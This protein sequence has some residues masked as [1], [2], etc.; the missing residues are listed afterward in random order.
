LETTLPTQ[1][2]NF[3]AKHPLSPLLILVPSD[4]IRRRLKV[5]L[6]IENHL[7][8]I[9]LHVLTFHQLSLKLL[10]ERHLA[11]D[12]TL[13]EDLFFEEA[14]R[15][16]VMTDQH[17]GSFFFALEETEGGI[18]ALWQTLRDMKDGLVDPNVT[19]QALEEGQFK[20][21]H[22]GKETEQRLLSLFQIYR[23]FQNRCQ[24]RGIWGYG[25]VSK[26][27]IEQVL[28]SSFLRQFDQ[29]F[30]Y[31]F[32]DLTQVQIDLFH[33]VARHYQTMLF[34]PF[35]KDHS[36]WSFSERFFE[37][38]VE[39]LVSDATQIRDLSRD[40]AP[41]PSSP[42]S[43][44]FGEK[45][46][47]N[48]I[49][50]P[51]CDAASSSII[52]CFDLRDEVLYVSKEIVRLVR[53][54]G[55]AFDDISV[56]S[57]D[58]TPYLSTI[59]DLFQK[60]AIP[61]ASSA[62]EP[63][64]QFPLAKT[65]SLMTALPIKEYPR[66]L[67]IDL[68]SSP[69]FLTKKILPQNALPAPDQWDFLSRKAG[70]IKGLSTW[71]RLQDIR[72][73]T[74]SD[75]YQSQQK[76][77]LWTIFQSVHEDINRLPSVASWS[78]FSTKWQCLFQKYLKPFFDEQKDPVLLSITKT[79]E[80]LSGLDQLKATVN[81]D[82]FIQTFQRWLA[83]QSVPISKGNIAG[84]R[85][86][87]LMSARGLPS[88]HR[89]LLGLNEGLFP[90]TIRED[91]F[92]PDTC[93]YVMETV[94]GYKIGEKHAGYEEER[95]LLRLTADAVRERLYV[96][97]HRVDGRGNSLAPSWYLNE[98]RKAFQTET[99]G[100]DEQSVPQGLLKKQS[101]LPF[102]E[103]D[104][105]LATESALHLSLKSQDLT[106]LVE[107]LPFSRMLYQQTRKALMRLEAQGPLMALDGLIQPEGSTW[108]ALKKKRISPT[109]LECYARCPFQ[110]FSMKILKLRASDRP[111][112]ATGLKSADIGQLCHAILKAFYSYFHQK[113]YLPM[114]TEQAKILRVLKAVSR[115]ILDRYESEEM[116]IY[117]LFW[118]ML[119]EKILTMLHQML[120][121]DLKELAVSGFRP[122]AFEVSCRGQVETTWPE[123]EGRLD[124]IDYHSEA[125]SIRVIDYKVTLRKEPKTFEKNLLLSAVRGLR[126][127]PPL[128]QQL[129]GVFSEEE[130][131]NNTE[132]KTI[133]HY[134][135]PNWTDGPLVTKSFPENAWE[136]ETGAMLKETISTLLHGM[137]EGQFYMMP[138]DACSF[139]EISEICRKNHLPSRHRLNKD[140]LWEQH[141]LLQKKKVPKG[142]SS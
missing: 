81:R 27:A 52:S 98:L 119:K 75:C 97:Y 130:V 80:S 68:V 22:L 93:R 111:E 21:E 87:G 114:L 138:G 20:K 24:A 63:I 92:L 59:K 16:Q 135:A 120:L 134:I 103:A 69:L 122:V 121:L 90:R 42:A 60:Y 12:L 30:Y 39:G 116:V 15:I 45:V 10:E 36:E 106:P 96:L 48:S 1:V 117:P 54:G 66:S 126:L 76:T 108:K 113:N 74:D 18:A 82:H 142:K 7:N 99:G 118:E 38:Y 86:E 35:V 6:T 70:V 9:H 133:F 26:M 105:F 73:V 43:H 125:Q 112:T 71:Q 47:S 31:G 128:Y 64:I 34:F 5:L 67:F 37:R 129:S 32:Y 50:H 25:D 141:Q 40:S 139:C 78:E 91:P 29:I 140:P 3:K 136:G 58:L 2:R 57:R 88:R 51:V 53:E 17:A 49:H 23:Q 115:E 13:Q 46:S 44:L 123:M 131:M 61:L 101:V 55:V 89:F 62:Q 95:L 84:V 8:L 85:V 19:I 100:P 110:F 124:R 11:S 109:A 14:L 94:L 28:Y 41:I 56:V 4:T 83:R 102:N 65:V 137:Q 72:P 77:L 79:L 127:Q 132:I 107:S 33:T 104:L